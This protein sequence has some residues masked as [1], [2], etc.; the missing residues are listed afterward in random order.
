MAGGGCGASRASGMV[1][2]PD[3]SL[4]LVPALHDQ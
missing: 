4:I 3:V 2:V 1:E